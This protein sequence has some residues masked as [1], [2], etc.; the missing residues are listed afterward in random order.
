MGTLHPTGPPVHVFTQPPICHPPAR[1]C[2]PHPP[3]SCRAAQTE[4]KVSLGPLAPALLCSAPV[5]APAQAVHGSQGSGWGSERPPWG[6]SGSWQGNQ[7]NTGCRGL[8]GRPRGL[9]GAEDKRC[10]G[11]A[12]A[13]ARGG[14]TPAHVVL[15]GSI[16]RGLQLPAPDEPVLSG[17]WALRARPGV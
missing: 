17:P 9:D 15:P 10:L 3:S 5:L 7:G 13:G 4:A 16:R 2:I 6:P 1:L 11:R 12:A 8:A 14:L